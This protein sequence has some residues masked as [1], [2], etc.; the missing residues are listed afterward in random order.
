MRLFQGS[1]RHFV[2]I[3]CYH[4]HPVAITT[5]QHWIIVDVYDIS[6]EA[7]RALQPP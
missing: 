1:G 5:E 3:D 7:D 2:V 6:L 4:G